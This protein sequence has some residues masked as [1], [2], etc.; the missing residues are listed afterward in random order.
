MPYEGLKGAALVP[1]IRHVRKHHSLA[2]LSKKI[3]NDQKLI[4]SDPKSDPKPPL[5]MLTFTRAVPSPR[6]LGIGIYLQ[7]LFVLLLKV[8]RTL[9]L[10]SLRLGTN[11]PDH[12]SW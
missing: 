5:L 4:Q 11:F 10:S 9:L 1:P 6:L 12:R 2:F 8:Q 7:I 3:S